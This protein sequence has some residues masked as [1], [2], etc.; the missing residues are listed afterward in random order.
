MSEGNS[1]NDDELV[2][3]HLFDDESGS[4][5]SDQ[6]SDDS[7]DDS[8][9]SSDESRGSNQAMGPLAWSLAPP[10]PRFQGPQHLASDPRYVW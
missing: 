3:G 2:V 1:S 10:L 6:S 7:S 5:S 8:S 9:S 4:D